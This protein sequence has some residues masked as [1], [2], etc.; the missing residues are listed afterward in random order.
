MVIKKLKTRTLNA[1]Y[2]LDDKIE[3]PLEKQVFEELSKATNWEITSDILIMS[4]WSLVILLDDRY[5]E[6]RKDIEDWVPK[7]IRGKFLNYYGQW[8]FE[9]EKDAN[10]F[11]LRWLS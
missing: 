5:N 10:W 1:S 6:N 8:I 11:K 4:G 9:D 2:S 3:S 7:N